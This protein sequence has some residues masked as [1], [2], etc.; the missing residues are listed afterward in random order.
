[1]DTRSERFTL[2]QPHPW[3]DVRYDMGLDERPLALYVPTKHMAA[4]NLRIAYHTE[5]ILC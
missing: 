3:L 2:P 1:M 4:L 5:Y